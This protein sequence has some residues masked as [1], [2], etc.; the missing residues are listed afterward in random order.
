MPPAPMEVTPARRGRTRLGRV[1]A[2]R[3]LGQLALHVEGRV[4]EGNVGV[5]GLG[6]QGR[7]ELAALH[8]QQHLDDGRQGRRAEQVGHVGLDRTDRAALALRHVAAIGLVMALTSMGSP[9]AV[10]EPWPS[11]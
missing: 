1:A 5:E 3:P 10:L 8:L 7:R 4:G 2:R 9:R 6:V 11:M